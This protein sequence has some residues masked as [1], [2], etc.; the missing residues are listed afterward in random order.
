MKY[1]PSAITQAQLET[2]NAAYFGGEFQV[3]MTQTQAQIIGEIDFSA[4]GVATYTANP[5][6]V[7]KSGGANLQ[8]VPITP[9]NSDSALTV[10]LAG[11]D[12]NT[13]AIALTASFA[14]PARAKNQTFN[15]G[16][17][18]AT[19]LVENPRVTNSTQRATA[20]NVAT[21]TSPN[22]GYL[23]GQHVTTTGFSVSAYNVTNVAIT[24]VDANHFT[25]AVTH[26]DE[27]TTADTGGVITPVGAGVLVTSVTGLT[28][29][30]GGANLI[31]LRVYQ[32]PELADYE[33]V[34][35]STE[36]DFNVKDRVA[37]G[38]DAGMESDYWVKRG[39]A[40]PGELS[41]GSKY[42]GFTKGMARY[43]GQKCT[44]M[45]IGQKEGQVVND[46]LVFTQWVGSVK[47]KL[48]DGDGEA[49]IECAGKFVDHLFFVAP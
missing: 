36:I 49:M 25:Y 24:V 3:L 46:Q 44:C 2:A 11:L 4:A 29:V 16:R 17:G 13:S 34:E 39:K 21:I 43:S 48:P 1:L 40:A 22:H 6:A 28:S 35:A 45:L 42:T 31:K 20:S 10:N 37:K 19:D 33:I 5:G 12:E 8:I 47:P 9:I 41:I 38:I 32:L 30:T 26:A 7:I 18:F 23:T 14:P 15:L 27:T